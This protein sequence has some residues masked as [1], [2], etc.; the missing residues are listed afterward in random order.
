M[1]RFGLMKRLREFDILKGLSIT[2]VILIH[3]TSH[4]VGTFDP[5]SISYFVY[6]ILNR[7]SQ[8]AV[9]TFI[10]ASSVLLSYIHCDS[11]RNMTTEKLKTFYRKR[12]LRVI[13]PY[14]LWTLVYVVVKNVESNSSVALNLG[15][16]FNLLLKGDGYYHLYFVIV[17]LQLYIFLPFIM[18]VVSHLNI[19]F[20]Y[21]LLF[22]IGMQVACYYLYEGYL[23]H[24]F[25][26]ATR[27][28]IWY[29]V[30]ILMGVWIGENYE[31]YCKRE[32]HVTIFL[33]AALVSGVLYTYCYHLS[34]VGQSVSSGMSN[35]WW[36]IY[37]SSTP[38]LLLYISKKVS[39]T[40]FE[41]AGQ[42]SFGIFLMHPLFLFI[43]NRMY[44]RVNVIVYDIFVF[45]IIYS[46]SYIITKWLEA[47]PWGKYIVG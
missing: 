14:L 1:D 23:I 11:F 6:L 20:H 25:P 27:L 16:Y 7:L 41:K 36:Y 39:A 10:F 43:M 8:F 38:L 15:N 13:P 44:A 42:L 3:V 34:N 37:V 29:L 33:P 19:K 46:L 17:I 9:P 24:Y 12:F 45:F 32:T 22:S 47:T 5:T 2:A 40:F 18:H 35:L 30:V 21:V 4:G 28:M 31:E 26:R